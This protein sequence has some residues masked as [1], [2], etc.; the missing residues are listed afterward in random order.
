MTTTDNPSAERCLL[1]SGSGQIA[2]DYGNAVDCF[3]CKPTG[4]QKHLASLAA[5]ST[6]DGRCPECGRPG[7]RCCPVICHYCDDAIDPI[8]GPEKCAASAGL[9]EPAPTIEV[10]SGLEA[11]ARDTCDALGLL[12]GPQATSYGTILSALQTVRD[13]EREHVHTI[14]VGDEVVCCWCRAVIRKA[15]AEL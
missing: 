12:S 11:V 8:L 10:D 3:E 6:D 2:D 5:P 15:G 7:G 1:C 4:F 9:C 14:P 13:A